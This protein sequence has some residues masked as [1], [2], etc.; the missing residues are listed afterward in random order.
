MTRLVIL[1]L[2]KVTLMIEFSKPFVVVDTI[3]EGRALFT[4]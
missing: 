1:T 4:T 3:M 2:Y